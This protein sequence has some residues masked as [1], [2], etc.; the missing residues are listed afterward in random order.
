MSTS[1]KI[2]EL[3]SPMVR[4][5]LWLTLQMIIR[6]AL[7]FWLGYRATGYEPLEKEQGA[8][9]LANHQS[10]LD[11][12]LIGLPLHRPI[13]FLARENLFSVPIIGWILRKTHVVPINQQSAGAASLRETIRRLHHGFLVGV[14]PEG[15]RTP[16]G[17]LGEFKP[18]FTAIIR[19]AKHPIY[20]VGIAGAYQA[21]PINSWF[22]K[23]TRV[24]VVYGKP[25]SAEELAQYSSRDQDAALIELVQNRIAA[26]CQAAETWR[27]TG[28]LPQA[29]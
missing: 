16:D 20:P 17:A 23:P 26:C 19:R 10:F 29:H 21:L 11:P 12:L 7:C 27:I 9:I 3:P 24:R 13:S 2:R 5:P 6:N 8:L 4:G 22:L 28:Q 1:P 15:A 18:G 25:L 14:F